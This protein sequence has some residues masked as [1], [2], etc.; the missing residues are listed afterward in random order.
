MFFFISCPRISKVEESA[1]RAL[2]EKFFA[3]SSDLLVE[4]KKHDKDDTGKT[5]RV[6][7][8]IK[9]TRKKQKKKKIQ[10]KS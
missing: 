5:K 3:H 10:K 6:K 9:R 1:L 2:R 8:K 4:F 7:K